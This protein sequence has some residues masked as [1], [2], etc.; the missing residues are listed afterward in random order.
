MLSTHPATQN[1][2]S[3]FST[4]EVLD[5]NVAR[6]NAGNAVVDQSD[7]ELLCV[8]VKVLPAGTYK[9]KWRVR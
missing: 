8:P 3:T 7:R 6:M 2:E 5:S 1:V 9:V 4:V